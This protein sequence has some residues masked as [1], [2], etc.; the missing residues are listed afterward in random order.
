QETQSLMRRLGFRRI[1]DVMDQPRAPFAARLEDFLRRLD[2][3]LGRAPEPLTP[4]A[5]PPVYRA[6]RM[7]LEPLVSADNVCAGVMRLLRDL[8]QN[9]ARDEVG[10]RVLRLLLFRVDGRVLSLDVGLACPSRDPEHIARLIALRLD[11]LG[12]DLD[13][14]FGFE[15][16]TLDVLV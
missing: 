10:A 1:G 13:A 16:A 5:P 12:Q 4:I 2:Q 9:L 14:E 15:V 3:A 11:R 8:V 7:F 6:Q